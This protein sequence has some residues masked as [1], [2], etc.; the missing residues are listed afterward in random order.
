MI[1]SE[2]TESQIAIVW[3]MGRM[4]QLADA[5]QRIYDSLLVILDRQTIIGCLLANELVDDEAT[6]DSV[7]T[8][9]LHYGT[10]PKK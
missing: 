1:A 10:Y 2:L 5:G 6:A 3:C 7:A 9:M 4:K 8:L